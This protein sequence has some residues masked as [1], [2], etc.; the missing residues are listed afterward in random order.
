MH[1]AIFQT[2][3]ENPQLWIALQIVADDLVTS[4]EVPL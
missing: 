1:A 4:F 2:A 3:L